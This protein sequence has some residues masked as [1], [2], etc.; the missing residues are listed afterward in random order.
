MMTKMKE[1]GNTTSKVLKKDWQLY[2][3]LIPLFLWLIFF[4]YKPLYGL[5]IA[6]KD[7]SV[8]KGIKDSPWV[9]LDHFRYLL[10]GPGSVFFWR[11]FKNTI[12]ISIYNIVYGFPIP[13]ILALMFNE[14]KN[15]FFRKSVQ[16]IVYL[17][18]FY[19]DVVIAGIIITL[20]SPNVGVI[21]NV[22]INMGVIEKG[23]YFLVDPKYFRSIFIL[24]DIWKT[25]GFNSIIYF[26]AMVG[27]SPMLYEA[28]KIDGASKLQQMWHIT[29]PS[30]TPTIVIMLILR[31][32]QLLNIGY[33][34]ILLLY[35]PQTY[36]VADVISTYIYRIGLKENGMLDVAAATGLFN[37]LIAFFLVFITNRITKKMTDTGL[38]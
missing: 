34:R 22:L 31:I 37:S 12:I 18:Y 7:F 24:S 19:S 21:N 16:T 2:V 36:E 11:A 8:F 26:A 9:G 5:L 27:I 35:T 30:L 17:P 25:A 29:L 6:F 14:V 33:E 3:L 15:A 38:W 23:I 4:A 28:A 10:F 1:W 13:I 20:L 32:G